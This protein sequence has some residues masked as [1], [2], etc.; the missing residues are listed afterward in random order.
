MNDSLEQH[1]EEAS[2]LKIEQSLEEIK[3]I[4]ETI[5]EKLENCDDTDEM[6]NLSRRIT[7]IQLLLY[8]WDKFNL[9]I[10]NGCDIVKNS[11]GEKI[12]TQNNG[13]QYIKIEMTNATDKMNTEIQLDENEEEL[14]QY[15]PQQNEIE[16]LDIV[17]PTSTNRNILDQDHFLAIVT[18]RVI[19][20]FE[21]FNAIKTN[22]QSI[23]TEDD[24]QESSGCTK[25][26]GQQNS[27]LS[28]V[29]HLEYKE[30]AE[31]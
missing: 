18:E 13:K 8:H 15:V 25:R 20:R 6:C 21:I 4:C 2:K 31:K 3:K 11:S 23:I 29:H 17:R 1:L 22:K 27:V 7:A 26:I 12:N 14:F 19:K 16:T 9:N 28:R 24:I 10:E 30:D 5:E